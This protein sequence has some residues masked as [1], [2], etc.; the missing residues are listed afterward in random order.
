[1]IIGLP[2]CSP[3]STRP[4]S[5]KATLTPGWNHIKRSAADAFYEKSTWVPLASAAVFGATNLDRRVSDYA[6]A[7][8]PVFGSEMGAMNTSDRML[9]SAGTIFWITTLA[10]PISFFD[11]KQVVA[12]PQINSIFSHAT[13]GGVAVG[14]TN[15]FTG[16]I[17]RRSK[18]FRPNHGSNDSLPSAHASSTAVLANISRF[19]INRMTDN[20][21]LRKTAD[22]S[23]GTLAGATAWARVEGGVHF[24]SDVLL[25]I[26]LA[27]YFSSFVSK[28][29]FT[30]KDY[31]GLNIQMFKKPNQSGIELNVKF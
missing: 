28:A 10:A 1:M 29:F 14:L 21:S 20:V 6:R 4:S 17:K 24:P 8:T 11:K 5:K 3:F 30:Q 25:G 18:R 7:N 9:K 23:L 2:A 16:E 26:A 27:N 22:Y 15:G 12:T 13:A 31:P 19:N